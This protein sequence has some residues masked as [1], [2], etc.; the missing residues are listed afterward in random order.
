MKLFLYYS[1]I[2]EAYPLLIPPRKFSRM[3][4]APVDFHLHF[5]VERGEEM[6][7]KRKVE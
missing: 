1:A 5:N 7:W 6:H 4:P 2:N 3:Q